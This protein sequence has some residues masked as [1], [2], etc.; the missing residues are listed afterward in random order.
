MTQYVVYWIRKQEHSDMQEGYIGITN[1]FSR[2]MTGHV[3]DSKNK[4]YIFYRAVRKYGWDNLVKSI[5]FSGSKF[6]CASL[7]RALRPNARIGWNV[8][9]GGFNPPPATEKSKL[10]TSLRCKGQPGTPHTDEFKNKLRERNMKYIYTI[11]HPNGLKET[12]NCLKD[13]CASNG[14]RQ[15]CMQ[16]VASGKR[17]QHK[18]YYC[19]RVTI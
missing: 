18:G 14:L 9:I 16:R 3:V 12:T 11:T 15:N 8:C 2:R 6:C 17:T 4:D 13:W 5:I 1:N 19:T 10:A 7:E